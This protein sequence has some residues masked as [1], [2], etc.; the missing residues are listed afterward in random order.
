[1][2]AS[3]AMTFRQWLEENPVGDADDLGEAFKGG[4][5]AKMVRYLVKRGELVITRRYAYVSPGDGRRDDKR[6][7]MYRAMR[8]L[9]KVSRIVDWAEVARIAEA[10]KSHSNAFLAE[11]AVHGYVARRAGG[12]AVLD[13]AMR[14][15]EPPRLFP[16]AG[17]PAEAAEV[18]GGRG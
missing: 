9:A 13:K 18:A 15:A 7:A 14:Q 5:V 17:G 4:D 10:G 12:V 2:S 8:A 6:T 1:M 3:K 16:E 11:L